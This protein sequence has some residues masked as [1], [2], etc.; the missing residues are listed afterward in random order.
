MKNRL[1]H[2][3]I[4]LFLALLSLCLALPS[5]AASEKAA[6]TVERL[7]A[8]LA[9]HKATTLRYTELKYLAVLKSPLKQEG[10]V[11]FAPPD[12]LERISN[13]PQSEHFRVEGSRVTVQRDKSQSQQFE[14][15]QFPPL[16]IFVAA[17]VGTLSGDA[18]QLKQH[19]DLK[20]SG[21]EFGWLLQLTPR[22]ANLAKHVS[23]I[24]ISGSQSTVQ[25]FETQ[26]SNGDRSILFF[27]LL[28]TP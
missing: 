21:H 11:R 10:I 5:F 6:W 9:V 28:P 13:P 20:L 17:F 4:P 2:R 26:Q 18:A 8:G 7:V 22:D 24:L 12:T 25:K 23:R 1:R 19:Y 27:S 3:Q 14:L 16:Q 15:S